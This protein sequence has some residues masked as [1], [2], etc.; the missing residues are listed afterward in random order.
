MTF[1]NQ[2]TQVENQFNSNEINEDLKNQSIESIEKNRT[3]AHQEYSYI[4]RIGQFI[5]PVMRPLGFDW[6]ISISLLTGMAAKEVVVSTLGVLYVGDSEN[7]ESL[8]DRLLKDT[9]PDGSLTF[10]PLVVL[11]LLIFVLIYFPC[12]ATVAA[13]KEEA[14][15][16]KWGFFSIIYT[17][18][19]AWLF[20]FLVFQIGSL[21]I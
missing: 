10:T 3:I 15:S 16:W 14:G 17:T 6:K 13:I 21:I 1:D 2:I 12:I 11:S 19:L 18:G 7:Q 9:Q 5:E 4:G 8:Q 20:S